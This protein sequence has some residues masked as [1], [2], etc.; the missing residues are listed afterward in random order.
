[1]TSSPSYTRNV[2]EIF[3]LE[4]ECLWNME[5][6]FEL[7]SRTAISV[8]GR[9]F[10]SGR[11]TSDY[12]RCKSPSLEATVVLF[13]MVIWGLTQPVVGT[14]L[15]R[16][17]NYQGNREK[18]EWVILVCGGAYSIVR[19]SLNINDGKHAFSEA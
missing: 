7:S 2:D 19:L 15:P 4:K 17:P 5:K 9:C 10:I 12:G 3:R 1:M 18:I 14:A 16:I 6:E 11:V 8:L 13:I